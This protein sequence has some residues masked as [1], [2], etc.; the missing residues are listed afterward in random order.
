MLFTD[1]GTDIVDESLTFFRANV[2][3]R[4]FEVQGPADR[5]LVYL[6]FYINLALRK[7]ESVKTE[8]E[9]IKVL[10]NFALDKFP[11]PGDSGF[12]LPGLFTQPKTPEEAGILLNQLIQ[13]RFV[14]FF[15]C[16]RKI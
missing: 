14:T 6:T 15:F 9:G 10:N 8:S 12:P 11:I 13:S 2:L 7:V 3:F 1:E 5:L 16:S 4:K